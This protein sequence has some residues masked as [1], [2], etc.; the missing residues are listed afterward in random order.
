MNRLFKPLDA[1]LRKVMDA[2]PE[3][4]D[5]VMPL[6]SAHR[7]DLPNA[8]QE[9]SASLTSE[10]G[11]L[12]ESYWA[13]PRLFSAYVRHFLPW[14]VFR[15]GRLLPSLD[16][17]TPE[18]CAGGHVLDVG[19]GPFTLPIALWIARPELRT[20]ALTLT[21]GDISPHVLDVGRALFR[22]IA[23]EECPWTL[24]TLRGTV[25]NALRENYGKNILV[26]GGNVLNELQPRADQLLE[27]RLFEVAE[28]L[29]DSLAPGGKALFVEPGSRLGGKLVTMLRQAAIENGLAPEAPCPHHDECP[30]LAAKRSSWCH[31]TFSV[32]DA[33]QWLTDI[34]REAGFERDTASLSFVFLSHATTPP[35]G[36]MVRV[37]SA[38]FPIP[39]RREPVRYGCSAEG[40]TLL[41]DARPL[42]S[43]ALVKAAW[44]EEPRTDGKSGGLFTGWVDDEGVVQGLAPNAAN[45]E[46]SDDEGFADG[47]RVGFSRTPKNF[48]RNDEGRS[49]RRGGGERRSFGDRPQGGFRREGRDDRD[50]GGEGGFR[51]RKPAFRRE[52][53]EGFDRK[54]AFRRDGDDFGR[55]PREFGDRP[56]GGFRREGRDDRDRGGEGGFRDRK[57]A[58]R[59][60]G[61]EGFDRKP[62][63]RRDG[64]DFGR[65][66]REFGD[67]P[68][69]GFRREGRDD[70]DRG[71][72]GGFRD[73]KPAFRREGGE[74][75]DRKPAFR[76][77]G[78]DFGRKPR[79]FGDRPQGGFRREGRDDRDRGGEGG[80]RDRKPAFRREGGEGFDRKP[81]F[82]RDGDDFGR[83]P[84]EFGDRPQGGF[85]REG[86][87]D[88]DRGGEGGFRDRKP[89][90]RRDGDDFGRKPREFGDRPQGGFRREGRDDRDRGGE[91]GFRDR[92][93]AFRREGGE[94]FDRKPAFRRD[95]D[96]FGR[97]P[98]EFGDRPQGGFRREGRDDRD[99]GGEGGFRD[100]KPAFRREGDA[101]GVRKPP[102]RHD[103]LGSGFGRK[104]RDEG[105]NGPQRDRDG[106]K[107]GF[108]D[109]KPPF[110]KEGFGGDRHGGPR[111]SQH[112]PRPH[113]K[114]EGPAG[115]PHRRMKRDDEGG[116]GGNGEGHADD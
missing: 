37:I 67:R 45:A 54:P 115:A 97:K 71:G 76:R 47:E 85:R 86:R 68:Q 63:F 74:G 43:G 114:G 66:P 56:Q 9:L 82:R 17:P 25:E 44:P 46:G 83:K 109:R 24:H 59:R 48:A 77:D 26:M 103:P 40:L 20:V 34:S 32:H 7:R 42:I 69:G 62:A 52:G 102:F 96:D 33:P 58:F 113:R 10:R 5:A 98:R 15:L 90:F 39:G 84:R 55:K 105:G 79:E 23:G 107:G 65:K 30:M 31:F 2:L 89:A 8:I 28:A 53:G 91:A 108:G 72:E 110:R 116:N 14:N 81:A 101:E 93:P 49:D 6:R 87:D 21:C 13:S 27:D 70:R 35:A 18:Q 19:S 100:R 50:R 36:D 29:R 51:D 22:K 95:G 111:F 16:L 94:G 38:V 60:E 112:Q 73:R 104:P 11:N 61:G 1:E 80:F 57:P 12:S 99:R 92:K 41:Y 4:I 78:D 3:A 75:F 88:R 106:G 64:D